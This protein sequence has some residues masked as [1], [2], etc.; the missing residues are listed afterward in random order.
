MARAEA[1][2]IDLNGALVSVVLEQD[3]GLEQAAPVSRPRSRFFS[4]SAGTTTASK[5]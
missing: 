1:D 2:L 3:F 5:A 4:S